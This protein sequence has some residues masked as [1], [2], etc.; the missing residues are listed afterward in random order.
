MLMTAVILNL[1]GALGLCL[2]GAKYCFGPA[3]AEYHLNVMSVSKGDIDEQQRI[4]FSAIYRVMGASF[5]ALAISLVSL[6]WFGISANILWAKL[7]V[8][9]TGAV[10]GIPAFSIT[11]GVAKQTGVDTPWKPAAIML[12][13][14][15]VAF[16]LSII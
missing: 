6:T 5:F 9:I 2:M 15:V 1:I 13:I 11:Y 3:P 16:I 12:V 4:V 10:I 8:L 7:A 14:I